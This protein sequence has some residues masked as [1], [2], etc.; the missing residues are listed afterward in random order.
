MI[1]FKD[2]TVDDKDLIQS[3]TLYGERQNCDLS[4]ANLISWRFL[5]NT[6]YAVVDDYLVFRFYTGRHLAYMMPVPRPREQEDGSLRVEPCDECS[7]SVIRAIR[8]DSIAMGHPFLMLGVCN[9]MRDIIEKYFPDTFDIKPDRDYS[10]YIYTRD[11]LVNLSGKKL[12]SK[13]NHI[14][15]FK[16]LYPGYE[17]RRLTPELIPQCL[18]V[19]RQWRAVSKDD[20]GETP[21]EELSEELRSMTR[22]FNRWDKLGLMGGAIFVGERMVAFTYGCPI[23]HNTFDVCVEKADVSYEG[24]FAI[25]NQEFVKHIPEQYYYINREED[26]GDEGLR[27]AKLSYKP[28]ILLE[29]NVIMEKHPLADFEDQSRIK[30]ET[31]ELWRDTFGDPEEF[32]NLYFSRVY[33]SE[34]NVCCQLGGRVVAALQTLPYKMLYHG[35]EVNTAYVSGVS[36]TESLRGQDIGN[37]L[38]RQAHFRLYYARTYASPGKRIGRSRMTFRPC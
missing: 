9:Y 12:Q 32:V 10:D 6:Q 35:R 36:V 23:N 16:T 1:K 24:A 17:Y 3:F 21:D 11:K 31:M 28:D 20:N 34:H 8:D 22:A 13:R 38:M 4:F 7:V 27:R 30:Q 37:N 14:N 18:E 33:K 25:I 5:Y 29:K 19:E 15:K 26:L 2:V